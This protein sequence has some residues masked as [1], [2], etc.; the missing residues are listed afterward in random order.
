MD[1][2]NNE[3]NISCSPWR[4]RPHYC[5]PSAEQAEVKP[6]EKQK[7]KVKLVMRPAGEGLEGSCNI[8]VGRMTH[9][10]LQQQ[11]ESKH[12]KHKTAEQVVTSTFLTPPF[13]ISESATVV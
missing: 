13:Q 3:V 5:S 1:S 8:D 12:K 6:T 9:L 2:V 10:Q 4:L 7:I 11:K